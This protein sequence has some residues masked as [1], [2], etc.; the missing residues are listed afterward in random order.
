MK[1]NKTLFNLGNDGTQQQWPA[2]T[3]DGITYDLSH[4]DAHEVTF[5]LKDS[6]L[7]FI[8][9]YS[10]HCFA[11]DCAIGTNSDPKWSYLCGNEL[12]PF[13]LERYN[14]SKRLPALI[15]NL[16]TAKT[17]YAGYDNYAFCEIIQGEVVVHYKVAFV[18]FREFKKFRLHITSAYPVDTNEY[19]SKNSVKFASILR[20]VAQ[21]K[22][23]PTPK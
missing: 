10:H 9:T 11:K 17:Y 2:F 3:C 1:K 18:A 4:L 5:K 8:V 23:P 7:R 22:K 6:N 14:L 19:T 13:N 20:N 16:I 15:P 12:R 21:G